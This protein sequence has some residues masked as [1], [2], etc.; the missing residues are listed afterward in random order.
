MVYCNRHPGRLTRRIA[1]VSRGFTLVETLVSIAVVGILTALLLP[2]VQ[3]ARA[4]ARTAQCRNNLHQIG[5]AV[6]SHHEQ[7]GFIDTY[8]CLHELLPFVGEAA[9]YEQIKAYW[10]AVSQGQVTAETPYPQTSPAVYVCP[11]DPYAIRSDRKLSYG[12]QDGNRCSNTGN[13]V[14]V[15]TGSGFR[16]QFREITDGL[17]NTALFSERLIFLQWETT[18]LEDSKAEPRRTVWDSGKRF[19]EG[20]ERGFVDHC[21]ALTRDKMFQLG[22]RYNGD[23]LGSAEPQY[24]HILG[25]NEWN[26]S[27]SGEPQSGSINASSFH[28]GG[29]H[30]LLADGS[31]RFVANQIDLQVWWAL[32]SIA[33]NDSISF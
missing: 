9:T 22:T 33:G 6:H 5:V 30:V 15:R 2:A 8:H 28:S 12:V 23:T 24:K 4:S 27:N 11:S 1:T 29:V 18:T 14:F 26:Y 21:R 7:Y 20:Q 31:V 13:G 16:R 3:S 10:N 19:I 32:G 25:P 17:S